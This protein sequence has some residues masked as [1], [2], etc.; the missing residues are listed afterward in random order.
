VN[1]NAV[2]S[3]V[4]Y[5]IPGLPRSHLDLDSIFGALRRGQRRTSGRKER[6]AVRIFGPGEIVLQSLEDKDILRLLQSVPADV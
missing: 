4:S 6:A 2:Q 1:W 3:A 5:D